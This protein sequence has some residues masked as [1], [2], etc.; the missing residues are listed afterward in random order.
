MSRYHR[1]F[2]SARTEERSLANSQIEEM[3]S[4]GLALVKASLWVVEKIV[5]LAVS[6]GRWSS[7]TNATADLFTIRCSLSRQRHYRKNCSSA[8]RLPALGRRLMR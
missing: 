5:A 8:S 6:R 4:I 2:E 7:L 3:D 1:I